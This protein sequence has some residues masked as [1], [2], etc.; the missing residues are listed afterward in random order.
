MPRSGFLVERLLVAA[1][2]FGGLGT[3]GIYWDVGWHR[4]IGRDTF[5][6]P[7]HL[8]MYAAVVANGA[9]A[10][11]A[12]ASAVRSPDRLRE[13]GSAIQ[14]P[15]GLRIPLGF[16]ILGLGVGVVL[17]AAP[18]DELWHWLYGKDGTVWSFPHLLAVAGAALMAL[19]IAAAAAS[20][21]RL[22]QPTPW[23]CRVLLAL[24]AADLLQ[25]A[26]F[27]LSHYTVDPFSRTPD[28]YP[29]LTTLLTAGVA[30]GAAR[31]LGP[32]WATI[33]AGIH[34]VLAIL[35]VLL[36]S[37]FNFNTP[38]VSPLLVVPALAV[39]GW[40]A[41]AGRQRDRWPAAVAAGISFGALVILTEA[42]W[43]ERVIGRPWL[44]S[45]VLAGSPQ[46]LAAGAV[47][48]WIGWAIGRFLRGLASPEP[49]WAIYGGRGRLVLAGGGPEP[50]RACRGVP[51]R[52]TQASRP[53]PGIRADGRRLVRLR[54]CG[55]LGSHA[56]R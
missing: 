12:V 44:I 56:S 45:A 47:S 46:V 5:W 1:V 20:R 49:A 51:S 42:F 25:K 2:L 7:P 14:G 24:L 40:M 21:S 39:D 27:S 15:F 53:A 19:G 54:G 43:M 38:T 31:A 4:T 36:L 23:F 8:L 48:G 52:A 37:A 55:L 28:Y 9:V 26:M 3:A 17:A 35:A 16:S 33:S 29:F 6:S 10:L 41:G 34:L 30:V 50:G 18:L 32:G 13:F 11:L 22:G